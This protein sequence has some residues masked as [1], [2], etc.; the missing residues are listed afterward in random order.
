M[1]RIVKNVSFSEGLNTPGVTPGVNLRGVS[2]PLWDTQ[3][4]K[5]DWV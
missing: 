5:F 3:V 2:P 1:C 4:K